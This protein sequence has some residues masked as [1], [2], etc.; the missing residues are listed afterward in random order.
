[1]RKRYGRFLFP[2]LYGIRQKGQQG[3]SPSLIKEKED[4]LAHSKPQR[5]KPSFPSP[6]GEHRTFPHLLA[7]LLRV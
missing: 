6:Q 5:R 3:L 1:M 7:M 4:S 2:C